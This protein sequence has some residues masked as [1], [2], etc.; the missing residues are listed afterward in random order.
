LGIQG[1][2]TNVRAALERAILDLINEGFLDQGVDGDLRLMS[3][4]TD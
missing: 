4:E 1:V 3:L 2:G